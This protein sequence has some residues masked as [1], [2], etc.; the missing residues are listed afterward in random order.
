[1]PRSNK[2]RSP[3][4]SSKTRRLL[5]HQRSRLPE[6]KRWE[7]WLLYCRLRR[8]PCRL[9]YW[10]LRP[11]RCSRPLRSFRRPR[12]FL[13]RQSLH[14]WRWFPLCLTL[15]RCHFSRPLEFRSIPRGFRLCP[16]SRFH[17]IRPRRRLMPRHCRPR[18]SCRRWHFR[19]CRRYSW[20]RRLRPCHPNSGFPQNRCCRRRRRPC[21]WAHLT[22]RLHRS[23]AR[24]RTCRSRFRREKW[25]WL[26]RRRIET[27]KFGAWREDP[28]SWRNGSP[29]TIKATSAYPGD[30]LAFP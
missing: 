26:L 13:P 24:L 9:R 15:R 7:S 22:P 19:R 23:R 10:S 11:C 1:M 29:G 25:R 5:S 14:H 16:R 3:P 8:S 28:P 27:A 6:E 20:C 2:G 4:V 30:W 12:S 18:S 17:P 21:P